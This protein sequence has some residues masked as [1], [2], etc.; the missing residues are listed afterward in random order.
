MWS[1]C[2]V[3][4]VGHDADVLFGFAWRVEKRLGFRVG[5]DRD[6]DDRLGETVDALP[7]EGPDQVPV[8]LVLM[9]FPEDARDD[10]GAHLEDDRVLDF[11]RERR[12][13][14]GQL[15]EEFPGAADILRVGG[16]GSLT[17]LMNRATHVCPAAFV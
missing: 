4:L 3:W 7:H 8:L 16:A 2:V 13:S 5:S 11:L 12:E 6:F 9:T 14:E 17:P 1:F 15:R 10:G